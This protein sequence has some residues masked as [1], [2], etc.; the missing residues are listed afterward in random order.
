MRLKKKALHS[1][2]FGVFPSL[3]KQSPV[4]PIR[5]VAGTV[6]LNEYRPI[7]ML[8]CFEKLMEKVVF[9]QLNEFIEQNNI[10]QDIQSGFRRHHSC[11]AALN[12][13]LFDWRGAIEKSETAITVFLDFQ[14]AFETIEPSLLIRKLSMY[15]IDGNALD[16]FKSYLN[17]RT[18]VVRIGDKLSDAL[19]VLGPLLF[20]LYIN[21]LSLVSSMVK[22]FA[23]DTL[24][25]LVTRNIM[26]AQLLIND[27]LARLYDK[28]GSNKLKL[29]ISKISKISKII[30]DN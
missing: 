21:D 16:W 8:P 1:L 9:Q 28:I 17:D 4:V 25:Y 24:N 7:N 18:Q 26:E 14:R 5:K 11:E 10:I 30:S 19:S 2:L 3:L 6:K 22:L 15:G 12:N 23:D 13:V 29:I 27:D 20:N